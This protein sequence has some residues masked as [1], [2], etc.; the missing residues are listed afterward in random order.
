MP[1]CAVITWRSQ[2]LRSRLNQV[3][4]EI[5]RS[6]DNLPQLTNP[7]TIHVSAQEPPN[8]EA[9]DSATVAPP[10]PS[11]ARWVIILDADF[12]NV[13]PEQVEAILEA[14]KAAASDRTLRLRDLRRGSIRIALEGSE[15]GFKVLRHLIETGQLREVLGLRIKEISRDDDL[16]GGN[17]T[18]AT[19]RPTTHTVFFSYS[20]KDEKLRDTLASHLSTLTR[21]RLIN[22]WHDRRIDPGEQWETAIDDHCATASIILL[23][24]SPDFIASDY[25][26]NREMREALQ[27]HEAGSAR[28]IPVILRPA[29]WQSTPFGRLQALP[30]MGGHYST[31]KSRR[32]ILVRRQRD[33]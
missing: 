13:G 26:Y 12:A 4:E 1:N 29:D 16:S 21:E 32:S 28:V 23:L 24:V 10:T 18:R 17:E 9:Q 25:C 11:P 8:T 6:S 20:H 15:E 31:E 2:I 33:S 7:E 5:R 14:L 30:G 3:D 27:R 19:K 22:G